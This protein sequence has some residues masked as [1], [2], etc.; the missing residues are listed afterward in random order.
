MRTYIEDYKFIAT[1]QTRPAKPDDRYMSAPLHWHLVGSLVA[2]YHF[3]LSAAWDCAY[4]EAKCLFDV[5]AEAE[6]DDTL[7]SVA[8]MHM[9]DLCRKA[10]ALAKAGDDA[11]AEALYAQ[12]QSFANLRK[13]ATA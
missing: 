2:R 3:T 9:N 8:D 1:H 13:E 6:G 11:G 4:N 10:D 5:W 12:V 7:E